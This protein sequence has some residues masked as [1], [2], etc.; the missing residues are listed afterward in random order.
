MPSEETIPT[1]K[2]SEMAAAI[3]A[4]NTTI[5]LQSKSV[6]VNGT[7]TPDSGYD[8]LS[9]VVVNVAGGASFTDVDDTYF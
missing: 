4:L 2:P 7:V 8:G 1:Y 3:L 6:I 5:N 9:E